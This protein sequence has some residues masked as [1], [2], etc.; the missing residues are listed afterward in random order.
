VIAVTEDPIA[1]ASLIEGARHPRVGGIV[2]FT[3]IV[4]DDGIEAIEVE[5]YREVAEKEITQIRDDAISRFGLFHVTII[6]RTGRL[7]V[8]ET[9]IAIV[10]GAGHRREAFE[11]C[12]YIIERIKERVPLWKRE[13]WTGGSRWV[14]GEEDPL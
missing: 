8:G 10:V 9:I 6:H 11:G 1:I 2:S 7:M 14:E 3:G 4:R 13:E 12:E 5:A